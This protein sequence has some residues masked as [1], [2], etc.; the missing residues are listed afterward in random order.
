VCMQSF[1]ESPEGIS[2]SLPRKKE[3]S[4]A[5]GK[6]P[7]AAFYFSGGEGLTCRQEGEKGHSSSLGDKPRRK[8]IN[9]LLLLLVKKRGRGRAGGEG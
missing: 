8:G 6:G 9:S 3:K 7:G 5:K 1:F 2:T 4:P